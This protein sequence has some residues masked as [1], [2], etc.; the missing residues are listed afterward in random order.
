MQMDLEQMAPG[1]PIHSGICIVGGGIAGLVLATQ[2]ASA[3]ID[4]T[5]LEAGG[6]E[7]EDRSQALYEAEMGQTRH[8]GTTLGRFRTFGGSSTRW[9]GQLLSYPEAILHPVPG[10]PSH[11]W[12]LASRELEHHYEQVLAIFQ[13]PPLP[14]DDTLLTALGHDT[15]AFPPDVALRYSKWAPF[16]RRNLAQTIGRECLDSAKIKLYTHAN[17]ASLEGSDGAI[18]NARVLDYSGRAFL[19]TAEHF[20]VCC[21]TVESSRLLLLSPDVPDPYGQIGRGF[22]DHISLPVALLGSKARSAVSRMLGPFFADG[23]LYTPKIEAA[24]ELQRDANLLAVMAHFTIEEPEDSGISAVRNVL[25]SIQHRRL[26]EAL[27][28]NLVPMIRGIGDIV[29]LAWALKVKKRR[30]IS[31]RATMRLNIDLEQSLDAGNR[32]TLSDNVDA[33]GLRKAMVHWTVSEQER[34]TVRRFAPMVRDRLESIGIPAF[35]WDPAIST[36]ATITLTD[37]YHPFGGLR[38][39][40][41]PQVSAV[42][43]QLKVHGTSNLYVASC[44]V[45]PSGGSSNPTFTLMA[46]T[47]RLAD[48][49]RSLIA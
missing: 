13:I 31:S 26:K 15:V 32:V 35:E 39:G 49:L 9:G 16:Q 48:H 17:V 22:G 10:S 44:A 36:G 38:M 7:L 30:G 18:R 12:P 28:K 45:F 41:D 42:D 37:T 21:G 24:S 25:T 46:L 29:R 11:A 8:T 40:S 4:V 1:E 47:M 6:L 5:L 3:G 20:V 19:F 2:M 34:E 14:F 33:L 43:T 27:T 23:V